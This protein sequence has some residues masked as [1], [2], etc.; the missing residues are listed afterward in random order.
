MCCKKNVSTI[1]GM[2]TRIDVCQIL[3]KDSRSSLYWKKNLQRDIC[4]PGERLTKNQAT[5]GPDH[6]WPEVWSNMGKAAQKKEHQDWANEKPKLDDARKL[7]DICF[8]DLEDGECKETIKNARRKLEVTV[9]AAMPCKK[10]QRSASAFRKL[11]RRVVNPTIF[12]RQSTHASWRLMSPRDNVWN[13]LYRKIMKITSQAKE[14]IRWHITIWCTQVY[15]YASSD[16][17]SRSW[18]SSGQGMEEARTIPAWQL[19]KVKSKKEVILEAPRDKRSRFRYADVHLS[20]QNA[21]LEPNF[22]KY[23]GRVVLRGD[24]V[25]RRLWSLCSLYWTRLV[26]VTND[27][28]KKNGCHC[29]TTRLSWTSSWRRCGRNWWKMLMLTSQLHFFIT[30]TWMHSTWM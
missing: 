17:H 24:S 4:G 22:Q 2:S 21:E 26:C 27:R 12:Q 23:K 6:V 1:I 16:E 8:I 20:S 15:S 28:S 7:R 19:D 11:K 25:K 30:Y 5:T 3:G 18:S 13:H 9:E 29:K 10:E 14:K